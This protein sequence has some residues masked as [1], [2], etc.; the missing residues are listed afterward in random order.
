MRWQRTIPKITFDILAASQY[1]KYYGNVFVLGV[2]HRTI[3]E[4]IFAIK[5]LNNALRLSATGVYKFVGVGSKLSRK[6]IVWDDQIHL[7]KFGRSQLRSI[8]NENF[9]EY[10]TLFPQSVKLNDRILTNNVRFSA[11]L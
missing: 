10:T 3:N 1:L 11:R 8:V 5:Q 2:P 4:V 6:F 9:P 7:S